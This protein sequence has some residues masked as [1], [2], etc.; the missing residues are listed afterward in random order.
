MESVV[1]Y[2]QLVY[3]ASPLLDLNITQKEF[4]S[5][6]ESEQNE[7]LWWGFFDEPSQKWL[8]ILMYQS[9]LITQVMEHLPKTIRLMLCIW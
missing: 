2:N 8:S 1:K 3:T 7:I 9:S 4:D 5:L 6:T